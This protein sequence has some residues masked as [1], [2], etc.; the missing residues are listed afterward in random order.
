MFAAKPVV[1][2]DELASAGIDSGQRWVSIRVVTK[3]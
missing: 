3:A 2:F 1:A